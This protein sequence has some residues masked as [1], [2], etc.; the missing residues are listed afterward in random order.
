[1]VDSISTQGF[2][3]VHL[4]QLGQ[5]ID[6]VYSRSMSPTRD[7][8]PV[9]KVGDL[10]PNFLHNTGVIASHST[11]DIRSSILDV[12]PVGGIDANRFHFDKHPVVME[13]GHENV[14]DCGSLQLHHNDSFGGGSSGGHLAM[15]ST[16][17][18]EECNEL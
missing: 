7:P 12:L 6:S 8:I 5:R 13:Y 10:A 15:E 1:M 9:D 18:R 11:P 17:L 14:T 16:I 4:V 2:L 3:S